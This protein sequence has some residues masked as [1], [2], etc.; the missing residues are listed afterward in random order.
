MTRLVL[1]AALISLAIGLEGCSHDSSMETLEN[2]LRVEIK[3]GD[4]RA[5]V[6]RFLEKQ[7]ISEY[8]YSN[9]DHSLLA[10][11]RARSGWP[12]Q[13]YVLIKFQF[14]ADGLLG[15]YQVTEAYRGP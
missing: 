11:V 8:S 10:K 2:A 12:V 1:V 3:K 7:R 5:T 4:S 14:N 6:E 9:R 13:S 15:S